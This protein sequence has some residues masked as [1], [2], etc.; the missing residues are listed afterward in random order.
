WQKMVTAGSILI[1]SIFPLISFYAERLR[2][3]DELQVFPKDPSDLGLPVYEEFDFIIVGGGTAGCI[4]ANRLSEKFSVLVLEA[5]GEPPPIQDVAII[6][7]ISRHAPE[8]NF[9]YQSQPERNAARDQNGH[10]TISGGKML[11]GSSSHN[12][13]IWE[14]CNPYD[15]DSWANITRDESWKYDNI[16]KYYIK[17]ENYTG[18]FP[19]DEGKCVPNKL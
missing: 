1:A 14:R 17:I 11:G 19:A 7:T 5:G 12:Y 15:F 8:I 9:L 13:M 2:K 10:V 6:N 16:L 3:E 4:L 18:I